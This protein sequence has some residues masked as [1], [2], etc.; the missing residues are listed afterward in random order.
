MTVTWIARIIPLST[1]GR[2]LELPW[3]RGTPLRLRTNRTRPWVRHERHLMLWHFRAVHLLRHVR[4]ED[5]LLDVDVP[6][7]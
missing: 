6:S 2:L 4:V 7:R 3:G 1:H 5:G